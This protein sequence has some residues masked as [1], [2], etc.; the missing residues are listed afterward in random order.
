MFRPLKEVSIKPG[1]SKKSRDSL[2]RSPGKCQL[3]N[4]LFRIDI[5]LKNLCLKI[6]IEL[7]YCLT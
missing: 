4:I 6:V 3:V 7:G 1:L 5:I 2:F